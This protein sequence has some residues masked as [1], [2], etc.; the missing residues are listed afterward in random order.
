MQVIVGLLA[1]LITEQASVHEDLV[2]ALF[3]VAVIALPCANLLLGLL[4]L[5]ATRKRDADATFAVAHAAV[6]WRRLV[7]KRR[8]AAAGVRAASSAELSAIVMLRRG[9]SARDEHDGSGAY[10]CRGADD[11]ATTLDVPSAPP[12]PSASSAVGQACVALVAPASEPA[13]GRVSNPVSLEMV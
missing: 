11:A 3:A 13:G 7:Q 12:P 8:G 10:V 2:I 1:Y 6:H 4:L 5:H 9:T